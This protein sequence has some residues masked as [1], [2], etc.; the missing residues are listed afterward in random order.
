M[1]EEAALPI[2]DSDGDW[3]NLRQS[4][5]SIEREAPELA[6]VSITDSVVECAPSKLA[7]AKAPLERAAAEPTIVSASSS[8]DFLP[9]ESNEIVM[10][11]LG[12]QPDSAPTQPVNQAKAECMTKNASLALEVPPRVVLQPQIRMASFEIESTHPADQ[13]TN[14]DESHFSSMSSIPAVP[15]SSIT[16]SSA[17][18]SP[19]S[20]IAETSNSTP[21]TI[22]FVTSREIS[23]N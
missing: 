12:S 10:R 1:E 6:I 5:T 20:I 13:K 7:I 17:T 9:A 22:T 8:S 11:S 21:T 15:V 16:V 4:A 3:S 19:K 23:F 18:A 14:V 2:D